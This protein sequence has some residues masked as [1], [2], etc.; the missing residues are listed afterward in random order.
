M[1]NF[2]GIEVSSILSPGDQPLPLPDWRKLPPLATKQ[3]E[4][5][6]AHFVA[7]AR[8]ALATACAA[9]D[10]ITAMGSCLMDVAV[11]HFGA[12]KWRRQHRLPWWNKGLTKHNRT[13]RR[14]KAKASNPTA[15]EA[16]RERYESTL[17][18]FQAAVQAARRRQARNLAKAYKRGDINF[19]W[20]LTGRHRGKKTARY[21]KNAVANPNQMTS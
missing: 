10:P 7:D 11:Q 20:V 21:L 15:S 13:L 2:E 14:S 12:K 1:V 5:A 9:P 4:A 6:K 19:A 18:T 3:G 8:A 17:K 16:D